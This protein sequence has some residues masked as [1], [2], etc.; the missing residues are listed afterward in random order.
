MSTFDPTQIKTS[1]PV[2]AIPE[3]PSSSGKYILSRRQRRFLSNQQTT[4]AFNGNSKIEIDIQDS[5]AFF[6][7]SKSYLRFDLTVAGTDSLKALDVGG[8]HALFRRVEIQT[9]SGAQIEN[10]DRYNLRHSIRS[11]ILD[12]P[13]YV[14]YVKHAEADSMN[15]LSGPSAYGAHE[16][17]GTTVGA[18][19]AATANTITLVANVAHLISA[20]STITVR[21]KRYTV[22]ADALANQAAIAVTPDPVLDTGIVGG[23]VFLSGSSE[24]QPARQAYAN[25]NYKVSM[26]LDTG[27]MKLNQLIPLPMIKGGIRL[28]LTLED[29]VFALVSPREAVDLDYSISN[30]EYVADMYELDRSI[31]DQY[32]QL[33]NENGF[34]YTFETSRHE[35]HQIEGTAFQ[36]RLSVQPKNTTSIHAVRTDAGYVVANAAARSSDS[37]STFNKA[38]LQSHELVVGSDRIPFYGR[39]QENAAGVDSWKLLRR[40]VG[41]DTYM[42]RCRIRPEEWRSQTSSKFI[43]GYPLVRQDG[44]FFAARDLSR[45]N[46][47]MDCTWT[48]APAANDLM[49]VFVNYSTMMVISKNGV[50]IFF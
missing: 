19:Q 12:S 48:G 11:H 42:S 44:D 39:V 47:I 6:N 20:G 27:L 26:C 43:L 46:A 14:E 36:Q 22:T 41:D 31:V 29:P 49:Q 2:E 23:S 16:G 25:N 8:S 35:L 30:V 17:V 37:L 3:I 45:E 10:L 5:S 50:Q 38:D 7:P 13:E 32:Q 1:F 34:Q 9:M 21:G 40:S 15:R 4:F 28:M 24:V 18:V 33:F